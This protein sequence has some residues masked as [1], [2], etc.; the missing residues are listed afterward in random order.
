MLKKILICAAVLLIAG[1][2]GI[3]A[4]YF[5][6]TPANG[7][8]SVETNTLFAARFPDGKGQ[9]QAISQWHGKTL[10][11]NFWAT[12]CP[13]CREEMPELSQLHA[14]YGDQGLVV[15]GIAAET[16]E[17]MREFAK[18]TSVSYPLLAGDLAAMELAASLGNDKSV[19][20]FTVII[21]ADGSIVKSY[22]GRVNKALLEQTLLPLLAISG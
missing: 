9:A 8:T 19:L 20:P 16:L 10:V 11:V 2:L 13:P 17:P 21:S 7:S 12:W 15:V 3:A 5:S 4:R 18:T 22:F 6:H 1:L 14:Q